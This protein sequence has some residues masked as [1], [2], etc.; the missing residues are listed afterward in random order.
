MKPSDWADKAHAQIERQREKREAETK[1]RLHEAELK[2]TYAPQLWEQ[3]QA[4]VTEHAEALNGMYP[5]PVVFI[6]S[7]F[8]EM[9]VRTK[10]WPQ[11]M[12]TWDA[13]KLQL[14]CDWYNSGT[15]FS[16]KVLSNDEVVF[17][18][19]SGTPHT[20]EQIVEQSLGHVVDNLDT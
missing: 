3:L 16:I 18:D 19:S 8:G 14:K 12:F 11:S 20:I 7:G 13:A 17:A 9:L 15:E 5:E 6:E 1:R 4:S 10:S 2:K